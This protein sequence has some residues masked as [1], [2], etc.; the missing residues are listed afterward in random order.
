MFW[1]EGTWGQLGV[2]ALRDERKGERQT[3][4]QRQRGSRHKERTAG[5]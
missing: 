2:A 1:G 3:D 4:R 5:Q